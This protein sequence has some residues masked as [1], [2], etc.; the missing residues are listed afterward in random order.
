MSNNTDI[1]KT[2]NKPAQIGFQSKTSHTTIKKMNENY[3]R[4]HNSR[5]IVSSIPNIIDLSQKTKL[6]WPGQENTI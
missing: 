2:I 1:K 5:V 6:L 3:K 4:G